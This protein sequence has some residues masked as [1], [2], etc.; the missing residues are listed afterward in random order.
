MENVCGMMEKE[1]ENIFHLYVESPGV[2]LIELRVCSDS[3]GILSTNTGGADGE[4][5]FQILERNG[6]VSFLSLLVNCLFLSSRDF[7][8]ELV[9]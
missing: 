3:W 2:G 7:V 4:E 8:V 6:S 1:V 9:F 5:Q